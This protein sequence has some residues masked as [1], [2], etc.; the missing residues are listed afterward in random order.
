MKHRLFKLFL[1]LMAGVYSLPSVGYSQ[2]DPH[3]SQY[4]IQPMLLNPALTGAIEGDYRVSAVWRTQYGNTFSTK[5]LSAEMPTSKNLNLGVNLLNQ[6]SSDKAY[7][8]S[9]AYLSVAYTGVRFGSHYVTMAMQAGVLNRSFNVNKLQFGEQWV[10]GIGYDPSAHSSEAFYKPNVFSFDA[11][12]GLLYYDATA[13]RK[14][15]FFGGLSAFHITRPKDPF[16]S[17]GER[18]TMPVRYSVHAGARMMVSDLL[19]IVPNVL[20]MQQ[21]EITEKMVG[22]Y[23]QVSTGKQADLMFGAN[24]RLGDAISPFAGIY[25]KGMTVGMSYDTNVSTKDAMEIKR[26]SLEVSLSY[27]WWRKNSM[28]TKPFFCPRF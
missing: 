18:Q 15:N 14:V 16:I 27:T 20:Y 22:A 1:L 13:D 7:N 10:S 25:Y 26:N 19:N 12:A 28:K 17:G 3:F 5:G 9:N 8:Y 2:T 21:G 24:L 23:V 6:S 11:G 4:F